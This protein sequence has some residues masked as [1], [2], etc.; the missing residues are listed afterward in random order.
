MENNNDFLPQNYEAP[1]TTGSYF[2]LQKG[3][4]KF[5]ILSKPIIGW[6]D[7]KDNKPMRFRYN[8]KPEAPVDA[9]KPVRHFWAMVVFDYSD[10]KIKIAEFTQSSIQK[11]I[12]DLTKDA[13][14]GSPF[15]YDIKI[16]RTG[17]GKETEYRLNP[18]PHKAITAE[19]KA[20]HEATPV[21]LD[22]LYENG[23]PFAVKTKAPF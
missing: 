2:K 17:E 22:A 14:W 1:K 12:Q 20:L 7:W 3:E 9:S 15:N 23:D 8:A 6:L 19:I 11:A 13:D 10:G 4:N 18:T 16:N 5:R 21:N